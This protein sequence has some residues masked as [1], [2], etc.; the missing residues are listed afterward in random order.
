MTKQEL[1]KARAPFAVV[2]KHDG[3]MATVTGFSENDPLGVGGGIFPSMP[4]A[5][6]EGGGW[7]LVSDLMRHWD[8]AKVAS[9]MQP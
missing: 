1:L 4:V 6:F 5:Y 8:I 3:A 9:E 7:S 2:S